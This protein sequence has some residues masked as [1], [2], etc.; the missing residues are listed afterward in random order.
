MCFSAYT[1]FQKNTV[2]WT[3]LFHCTFTITYSNFRVKWGVTVHE[4]NKLKIYIIF[5]ELLWFQNFTLK[6]IIPS[7][8]YGALNNIVPSSPEHE[9]HK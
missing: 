6:E 2:I 3:P 8:N 7:K 5:I 9:C 1:A 4:Y